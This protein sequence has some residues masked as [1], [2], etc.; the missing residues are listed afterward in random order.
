MDSTFFGMLNMNKKRGHQAM[1]ASPIR[2][3]ASSTEVTRAPLLGEHNAEVLGRVRGLART[4]WR[5]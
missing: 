1:P 2:M 5:R 3:S 4:S